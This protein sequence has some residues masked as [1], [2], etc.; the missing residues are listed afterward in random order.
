MRAYNIRHNSPV[1]QLI[2]FLKH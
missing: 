2:L 1:Y